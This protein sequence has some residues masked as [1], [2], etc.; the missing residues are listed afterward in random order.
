MELSI[1]DVLGPVMIGPSSSHTAGAAKLGRVAA[2]IANI[3][4]DYVRFGWSGSFASTGFGH[5]TDKALLAGVLGL[6]EDDERMRKVASLAALRGVQAEYVEEELDGHENSVHICFRHPEWGAK[7]VWGS[8][9]GGGR[10]V[11]NRI[12]DFETTITAE[13]PTL[14]VRH[15]DRPGVI[16]QVSQVLAAEGIN[17]AVLRLSRQARGKDA[18][19]VFELDSAISPSVV[20]EMEKIQHVTEVIPI[21]V[22]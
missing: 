22:S 5:G 4:F 6:R 21:D 8:S 1:F 7:E 17:I 2:L 16:S 15:M 18:S 3:P 10:I 20:G 12:G 19:A 13:S 9:I 14:V 11:I